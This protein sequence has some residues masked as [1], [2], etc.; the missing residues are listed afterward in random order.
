MQKCLKL[1]WYQIQKQTLCWE[2]ET[3]ENEWHW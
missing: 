3:F 2:E 1:K